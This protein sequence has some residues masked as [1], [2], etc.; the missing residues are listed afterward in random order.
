[1]SK[2]AQPKHDLYHNPGYDFRR[3]VMWMEEAPVDDPN[4]PFAPYLIPTVALLAACCAFEGYLNMVGQ[5]VDKDWA[6]FAKGRVTVKERIARVYDRVSRTADFGQGIWQRV[7]ELFDTRGALVHPHYVHER[8]REHEVPTLFQTVNAKFPPGTSRQ[9]LDEALDTL[10]RDTDLTDIRE[11]WW[12]R[13]YAG[14]P[15]GDT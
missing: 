14:P 3:L 1:M 10:L 6:Q 13:A 15:R 9:L 7:L 5:H 12:F 8:D 11:R 4:L 2:G